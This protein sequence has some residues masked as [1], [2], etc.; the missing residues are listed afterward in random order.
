MLR[1]IYAISDT[2]LTPK[3]RLEQSLQA[4]IKGGIALF[5]LRDK[6][7]SD[8]E[9]ATL[10]HQ[11]GRICQESNVVFVLNDRV[12][13][14]IQLNVQ[15]LHIGKKENDMPYSLEEL[16]QIRSCYRGILGVSCYGDL[17]LAEAAKEA[18]A[19]YVAFGACFPSSTKPQ[20]QRI[21]IKIFESFNATPTCAIGGINVKN[22]GLLKHA[23][24]VA[25]V[26][27][28]WLGDIEQNVQR[29]IQNWQF[30]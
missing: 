15:A 19:D 17:K 1:G 12:E 27:S 22:I 5:Q 6:E 2:T 4:A 7:S 24:M 26:R 29:L 28:I 13:L 3:N 8:E 16:C 14:A 20:A 10:C 11:L 21:D 30:A 23:Q 18:K 25:C 9:I